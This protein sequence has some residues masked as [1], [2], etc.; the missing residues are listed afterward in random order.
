[1]LS[2]EIVDLR[3]TVVGR[4]NGLAEYTIGQ[5]KG[6]QLMST[7]PMYV[8]RK[9][10][11]ANALVV[12]TAGELGV[13]KLTAGGVNWIAG[14]AMPAAFAA[15]VKTRYTARAQSAEV[16]PIENGNRVQVDFEQKQRDITPGQAAVF[17]MEDL[18][19]GGG[20]IE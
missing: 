20:I 6:L 11:G 13:N 3:G 1:M 17:Y 2:G 9:D 7:V 19:V 5:R 18:V 8:L 15:Q 14:R 4:H 12:G 16:T 10:I